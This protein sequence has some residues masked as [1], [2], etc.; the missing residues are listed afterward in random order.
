VNFLEVEM[1]WLSSLI[2]LVAFLTTLNA[3]NPGSRSLLHTH[4]AK[5]F[6]QGRLEVQTDMNF[7]TKL[8]EH[9]TSSNVAAVNYWDVAGNVLISYGL[10]DNLDLTAALRVYQDTHY[11]GGYNAPDDLF[12]T[13]KAGSF[14]LGSRN[15]YGSGMLNFRFGIG[16]QHNYP[17][18]EYASGVVEYGILS[19]FSYY[20]DPY[21]FDR[22]FSAH[23]NLGW[24]SHN[25]AGT[26][27]Y[28]PNN[29]GVGQK[30]SNN[31]T[32]MQYGIG[33]I[34]PVGILDFMLEINGINFIEQP[35]TMVYSREN[36]TYI[37]PSIR[38]K[39]Y[40]WIS[41]DLG[42]DI[43]LSS[44]NDETSLDVTSVTRFLDLPNYSSWKVNLGLNFTILPLGSTT[45]SPEEVE[46]DRFNRRIE[47]FQNIIEERER[48]ETVQEELERL[49]REREEA[50]KELEE[51]KQILEE[52]G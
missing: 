9:L 1:R 43:R 28:D 15:F 7:F 18:A 47:F 16:E 31:A 42:I 38:Y 6:E 25:D 49:K 41:M 48:V 52:E 40:S 11:R 50:E 22:S 8:G 26:V 33:F 27:V 35:D 29:D 30:A 12:L 45:Y 44:D 34:Y 24:Y 51:L 46:R 10:I 13:L 14:S 2:F 3:Q 36:Y 4:T 21:L 32:E 37:T 20:V 23:V 39:P 17:F 5:T 19:A